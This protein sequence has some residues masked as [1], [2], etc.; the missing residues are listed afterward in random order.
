MGYFDSIFIHSQPQ[1]RPQA[2]SAPITLA[3]FAG[4]P[5]KRPLHT[6]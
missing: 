2:G 1:Q 4:T 6:D 3:H 5:D